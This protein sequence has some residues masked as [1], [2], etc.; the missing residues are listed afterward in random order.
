MSPRQPPASLA[1]A[2]GGVRGMVDGAIPTV[3]F[4]TVNA[5]AGLA[6]GI[7]VAIAV[8]A[9]LVV[10]RMV[11]REPVQQAF[12][13]LF[14]VAVAAFVASRT[15]S[16]E[17]FFLP[18]IAKN[19]AF[20]AVGLLSLLARRP[21]AGYVM[22]A[23]DARYAGWRQHADTRRAAL[24]AT[25]VWIAVFVVRFAV[26]GLLYLAGE[27][28]WLGAANLALGLP[29]FGVAILAT[30]AIVRRLAPRQPAADGRDGVTTGASGEGPV[31]EGTVLDSPGR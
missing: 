27:P 11:R 31:I 19:A 4:V 13:G 7:A 8:A 12:S 2:V 29:L 6:A 10:L 20:A 21:L 3:A 16:A 18:S 9:V 17:G 24:W 23:M 15:H 1:E 5:E 22:A 26:Q 30:F 28:G 14:A 25:L